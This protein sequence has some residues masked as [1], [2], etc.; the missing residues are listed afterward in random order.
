MLLLLSPWVGGAEEETR[1]VQ[2][3]GRRHCSTNHQLATL[4]IIVITIRTE[5]IVIVVVLIILV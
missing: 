5:I 3:N 1:M 2:S 4:V